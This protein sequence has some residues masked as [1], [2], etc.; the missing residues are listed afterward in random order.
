MINT[1]I[2]IASWVFIC[3]GSLLLLISAIGLLRMPGLY[4]RMQA[5]GIIDTLGFLLALF[6][7]ILQ[8]EFGALSLRLILIVFFVLVTS[9]VAKHT[10]CLFA[11]HHRDKGGEE[12]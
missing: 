2:A 3:L 11:R 12:I 7:L 6:G 4:T 10:L 1:V 5:A 9:P 8:T